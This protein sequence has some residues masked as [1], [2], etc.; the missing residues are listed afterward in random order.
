MTGFLLHAAA[1]LRVV[2][3]DNECFS[4]A[5]ET[6]RHDISNVVVPMRSA[7]CA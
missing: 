6:S 1:Y 7:I 5:R 2:A 3:N 4:L